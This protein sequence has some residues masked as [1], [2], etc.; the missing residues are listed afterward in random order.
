MSFIEVGDSLYNIKNIKKIRKCINRYWDNN[1][2]QESFKYF[3]VLGKGHNQDQ[4]SEFEY[5]KLKQDLELHNQYKKLKQ[6]MEILETKL[7]YA[8]LISSGFIE[9]KES[10]K[11]KAFR[12]DV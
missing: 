9:A 5:K 12:N 7:K 4:I 3:I 2:F 6:E 1:K 8:P 11:D 10:F